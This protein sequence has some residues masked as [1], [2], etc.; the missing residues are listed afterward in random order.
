MIATSGKVSQA[1][2]LA[3]RLTDNQKSRCLEIVTDEQ[4]K[5]FIMSGQ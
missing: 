5:Q 2:P 4:A 3:N 1:P